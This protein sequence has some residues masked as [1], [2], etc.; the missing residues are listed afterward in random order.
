MKKLNTSTN[1]VI[2]ILLLIVLGLIIQSCAKSDEASAKQ[3][4][5]VAF[6]KMWDNVTLTNADAYFKTN[7]SDDFFTVNADGI[8]RT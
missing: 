7:V 3:D 4:L 2:I 1:Q 5:E 8:M 6:K